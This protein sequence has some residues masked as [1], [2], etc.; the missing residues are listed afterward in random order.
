M[1]SV[2]RFLYN[3]RASR[4]RVWMFNI[5][6]Y[7]G[8][9]LGLVIALVGLSGSLIVY[10]PETERLLSSRMAAVLPMSATV[11]V[12]VLYAQAHA[13][14][15]ADRIDRLYTW[16]GPAAAWMFRTIRP[17]GRRQYVYVDQYRGTVLGEYVLDGSALQWC[18]ELHDNLLLGQNGL[19]ANGWGALLL[20]VLCVSGL[21]I[22]WPGARRVITGFHFHPRAGWKTQNYDIHK[23]LGF[24]SMAPLAVIAISGAYYAFPESYRRISASITGTAAYF[25]PPESRPPGG[26]VAPLEQVFAVARQTLPNAELSILT[27]PASPTAAFTARKRLPGDWSRLGNQYV[28]IDRF[29]AEALRVDRFDQLPVGA[30]LVQSMAPLHYGSF[31]G[32]WTRVLWIFMGLVPGVLAISGFLM[33]WNR[34]MVKQF[35]GQ[36][37]SLPKSQASGLRQ[38]PDL[39]NEKKRHAQ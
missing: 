3:P 11:S 19:V 25:A 32:H 31:G 23:I 10:K 26:R 12:E 35:V 21:V 34:V 6:L 33:W 4:L 15:P 17:D 16:G 36:A 30:R 38:L 22:W 28:Y 37:D 9:A 5:H 13:F 39:S 2:H 14:R 7:S 1:R 18:Y 29:R 27:F 20:T 24:V 8:L